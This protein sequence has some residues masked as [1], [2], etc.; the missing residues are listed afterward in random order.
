MVVNFTDQTQ[1]T[2]FPFPIDGN[3]VE[4]LDGRQ[5]LASVVQ[6]VEQP[7]SVPSNYGC[8]WTLT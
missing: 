3:Y 8:I 7:I 2:S 5:N 6:N 1:A 4:K